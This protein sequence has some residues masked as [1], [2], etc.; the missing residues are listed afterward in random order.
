MIS[1]GMVGPLCFWG[2]EE[3]NWR[4]GPAE[5]YRLVYFGMFSV[6]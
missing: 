5:C 1:C 4:C 6:F 3:N 2:Q